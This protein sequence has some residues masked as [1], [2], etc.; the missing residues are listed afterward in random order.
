MELP[1]DVSTYRQ[2]ADLHALFEGLMVPMDIIVRTPEQFLAELRL[3]GFIVRT[4]KREGVLLYANG[5]ITE[6]P[7]PDPDPQEAAR[8]WMEKA[9]EDLRSARAL[10]GVTPPVSDAV[11]F[12]SQQAAEKYLKAILAFHG[13][14]PPRTHDLEQVLNRVVVR[15]AGLGSLR[16][17]A[18]F[19]TPFA[20]VTRYPGA[21]TTLAQATEAARHAERI[22]AAVRAHFADPEEGA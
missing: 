2:A 18:L 17:S 22:G 7:M 5:S 19:L 1:D 12:H 3:P 6:V 9:D 10:L 14:D 11:A 20:V 21:G 16:Q 8:A 4:A 15:A 13:E